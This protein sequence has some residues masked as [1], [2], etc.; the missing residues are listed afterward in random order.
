MLDL[1]K[2]NAD[3][4]GAVEQILKDPKLL[5]EVLEGAVSDDVPLKFQSQKV[6]QELSIIE[7]GLL[8]KHWETFVGMLD[9][10]NTFIKANAVKIIGYLT[11]VDADNKFDKL[12]PKFYGMMQAGSMITAGN[13]AGISGFI[14]KHK[15][16]LQRDII[17]KLVNIDSTRHNL[18]CQNIIKGKAILSLNDFYPEI[19]NK[20]PVLDFVQKE[21]KN[22]RTGT[23][24]KAEQFLKRWKT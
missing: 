6:L 9:S 3:I 19:K 2:K 10:P 20:Q 7:P 8:Y 12:F 21:L 17:S 16:K 15:P 4:D 23:Q 1:N 22:T 5:N 14:A 13:I 11:A 18:E 24:R